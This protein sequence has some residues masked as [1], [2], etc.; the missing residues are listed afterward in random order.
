MNLLS[1]LQPQPNLLVERRSQ[2]LMVGLIRI[3]ISSQH[4]LILNIV[5]LALHT[6]VSTELHVKETKLN[7]RPLMSQ[8]T[9]LTR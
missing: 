4:Q 2:A 8:V 5:T 7:M 1:Q 6:K 3:Q 9:K